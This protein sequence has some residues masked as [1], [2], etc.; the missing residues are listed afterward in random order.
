MG[1]LG[2]GKVKDAMTERPRAVTPD[3]S[4]REAAQAMATEDV[5]ALP[6]LDGDRLVGVVT[7]RDI[8][9]RVVGAGADVDTPVARAISTEV[10]TVRADDSLDEAMQL[11]AQHQLR[12]LPVVGEGDQLIGVIAQAD[13]ARVASERDT[14]SV[15]EAISEGSPDP[16]V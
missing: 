2:N 9:V 6:V 14:G 1:L 10:V 11:M 8:A 13:I 15:V 12:R 5:G 3:T 7:D 4:A 16:R